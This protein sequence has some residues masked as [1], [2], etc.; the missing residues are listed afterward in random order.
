[1]IGKKKSEKR[2]NAIRRIPKKKRKNLRLR[3]FYHLFPLPE[4]RRREE[5]TPKND[6]STKSKK[7]GG[8]TISN[9]PL[10]PLHVAKMTGRRVSGEM[11]SSSRRQSISEGKKGKRKGGDQDPYSRT[12]FCCPFLR[13]REKENRHQRCPASIG[14]PVRGKRRGAERLSLISPATRHL[15]LDV[16]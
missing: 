12:S 6:P 9:L 5:K 7:G 10:S 8:R 1:M 15:P 2:A 16:R 4:R 3:Y 13:G 14:Q 11:Y